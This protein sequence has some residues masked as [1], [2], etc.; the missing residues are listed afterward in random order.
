M[1]FYQVGDSPVLALRIK[2]LFKNFPE[3]KFLVMLDNNHRVDMI[4]HSIVD[5]TNVLFRMKYQSHMILKVRQPIWLRRMPPEKSFVDN[6]VF[7]N[8]P[9]HKESNGSILAC[10]V[11]PTEIH[12]SKKFMPNFNEISI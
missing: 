8:D 4:P 12:R 6:S 11:A 7:E 9:N 5:S 10:L 2:V 1:N 3:E